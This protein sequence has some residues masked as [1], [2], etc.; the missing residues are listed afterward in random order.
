[1]FPPSSMY[2]R[3]GRA[4]PDVAALGVGTLTVRDGTNH[5]AY[6]TSTSSP[7]WAGIVSILNSRSIKITGKTL[8]FLNPLLYK[9]AKE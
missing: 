8:G 6:G 3:Y 4:Y 2:N 9:M 7:L 1:M 5:L